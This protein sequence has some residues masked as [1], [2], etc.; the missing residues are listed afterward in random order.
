MDNKPRKWWV[1]GL[2]SLF[3]P[4]LGQIYNGQARKG[5]I[6]ILLQLLLV[7]LLMLSLN[8]SYVFIYLGVMIFATLVYYIIV[9]SDAVNCARNI[10][11][12]Y[13]L[14]KY[15]KIMIY[16]AIVVLLTIFSTSVKLLVR[17]NYVQAFK[18]PAG[19]MEPTLLIGDHILV[20]RQMSARNPK[21]GDLVIFEYPEDPSKDFV[22]RVVA[23]GGDIVA[24]RDKELYI[25]NSPVK[26]SYS[27]HKEL[28]VIQASQNPRDNYGPETVPTGSYFMMGDNRDRSYDS[29]FWGFVEKSK[30]KGTVRNI[31]WSWDR[32]KNEVRW[33]RI[34]T[35]VL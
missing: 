4:G 5:I 24:I 18:I 23:V 2:L 27:V 6:I 11:N 34:G 33:N 7:P 13:Q 30:I 8:S 28:D 19:S 12:K 17:N 29:R 16:I 32:N 14:K 9:V 3:E 31:Y 21:R 35:K 15:N 26:E 22:K 20:D 1:A 10:G 25:N